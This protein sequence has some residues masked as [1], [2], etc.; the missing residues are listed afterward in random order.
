MRTKRSSKPSARTASSRARKRSR[1]VAQRARVVVA[2][3]EAR[4]TTASPARF[5]LAP[6]RGRRRQHSARK[7]VL[8]DEV[9]AD[10]V[11]IEQR[12]S[13]MMV[14]TQCA[15][16]GLEAAPQGREVRRPVRLADRL[17]HLDRRDGVVA[18]RAPR[19]SPQ[20]QRPD[21]PSRRRAEARA[22]VVE[23]LGG[24]GE[25]VD[26]GR[27]ASASSANPPQPQPISSTRP[28]SAQRSSSSDAPV[29]RELAVDQL[30]QRCVGRAVVEQRAR[31]RSSSDPARARRRRCRGRSARGCCGVPAPACCG[32]AGAGSRCTRRP[33]ERAVDQPVR[34][35]AVA[36]EERE[37]PREIGRRPVAGD[38]RSRRSRCRRC[39]SE[40]P[41]TFQ[42]FRTRSAGCASRLPKL[43]RW[44]S[45]NWT[46]RRP[47]DRFSSRRSARRPCGRESRGIDA[48]VVGK[49]EFV[50]RSTGSRDGP[51][52][53]ACEKNGTR[54]APQPQRL[55]VDARDH[56]EGE[57]GIAE[58]RAQ[59]RAV[60][61]RL[62]RARTATSAAA[63]RRSS[64]WSM[65]P[66][67]RGAVP[68]VSMKRKR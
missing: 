56:A 27:A 53:P 14:W 63:D 51:A 10:A 55:P 4:S 57:R 11:A 19:D 41:K 6:E 2:E 28:R 61:Q 33:S 37:Q 7:D 49:D 66:T 18:G 35:L 68:P 38:V 9:G 29:L 42:L 45:G 5:G 39:A 12:S 44:P 46:S 15:A 24:Q 34:R 58:Q 25:P 54:F 62:Q 47:C 40:A 26:R 8:L 50:H 36:K 60:G 65:R 48:A 21:P 16:A 23:L 22:R 1:H 67:K 43:A 20:A 64:S 17:E 30:A 31:V 13:M 59:Q 52:A 3:R 32:S